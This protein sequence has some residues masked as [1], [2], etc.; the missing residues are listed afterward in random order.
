MAFVEIPFSD[1]EFYEKL[2]GGAAGSVYRAKWISK[3]KIVAVK[4]LL[5]IEREVSVYCD[6]CV[7]TYVIRLKY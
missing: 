4:K 1:L 2:G 5:A 3:D 6:I 7:C